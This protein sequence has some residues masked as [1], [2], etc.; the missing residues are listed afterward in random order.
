LVIEVMAKINAR[1]KGHAFE[2][3]VAEEF[4]KLGFQGAQT[5]RYGSKQ[6]D[7]A[8]VDIMNVEPFTV[9]CKAVESLNVHKAYNAVPIYDGHYRLLFHK[10]NRQGTLV[11]MSIEDWIELIGLLKSNHI[12]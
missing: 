1:K 9:Q 7:D 5:T 6:M 10:K 3:L 4:R 8:G 2:L 12:L 11:T